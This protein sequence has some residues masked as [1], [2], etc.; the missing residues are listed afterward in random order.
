MREQTLAVLL[1]TAAALI[2]IGVAH[3][4]TGAAFITGG[5]LLA[6]WSWLLFGDVEDSPG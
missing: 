6:L 5:V 3:F 1:A 2:V 4:S